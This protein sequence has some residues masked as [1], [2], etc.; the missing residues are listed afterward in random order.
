[1][2][3]E[4]CAP[5]VFVQWTHP[6]VL[7]YAGST[8]CAVPRADS[9]PSWLVASSLISTVRRQALLGG[10]WVALQ[11]LTVLHPG[12]EGAPPRG[13]DALEPGNGVRA[14]LQFGGGLAG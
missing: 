14:Q 7:S 13:N 11:A 4:D 8:T 2:I 6:A 9:W 5:A 10:N 12:W 3:P 1:M